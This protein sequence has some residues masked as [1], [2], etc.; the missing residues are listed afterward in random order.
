MF[1]CSLHLPPSSLF[2]TVPYSHFNS[3]LFPFFQ[4]STCHLILS[5]L[6]LHQL[7]LC[8]LFA[9]FV[10]LSDTNIKSYV[11]YSPN[12]MNKNNER[13]VEYFLKQIKSCGIRIK[14]KRKRCDTDYI[15]LLDKW[16]RWKVKRGLD[17]GNDGREAVRQS[18]RK[19][20]HIS[21][22]RPQTYS[23]PLLPYCLVKLESVSLNLLK[24][25]GVFLEETNIQQDGWKPKLITSRDANRDTGRQICV[26]YYLIYIHTCRHTDKIDS[27]LI[28]IWFRANFLSSQYE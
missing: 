19:L 13:E 11:S 16:W 9:K 2:P 15:P 28:Y 18:S 8:L 24:L 7:S 17:G 22:L 23:S 6:P 14:I 10:I 27:Y 12:N 26:D 5:Y 1:L 25:T 4:F 21:L 20:F 3:S